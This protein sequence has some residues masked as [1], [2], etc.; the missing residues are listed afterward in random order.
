MLYIS[1]QVTRAKFAVVDTDDNVEQLAD[2]GELYD[3]VVNKGLDI[4][5]VDIHYNSGIGNNGMYACSITPYMAETNGK[6]AKLSML[7][8]VNMIVTNNCLTKFSLNA[9]VRNCTINLSD[10]CDS[11]ADYAT[12]YCNKPSGSNCDK[13][14]L[15]LDSSI[16]VSSK[17]FKNLSGSSIVHIDVSKCSDKVANYVYKCVFGTYPLYDYEPS[18]TGIIDTNLTRMYYHIAM[19]IVTYGFTYDMRNTKRIEDVIYYSDEL[20]NLVEKSLSKVFSQLNNARLLLRDHYF[21][22]DIDYIINSN[23]TFKDS[24]LLDKNIRHNILISIANNTTIN[25]VACC[26]LDRY[27]SYINRNKEF[28]KY[29]LNIARRYIEFLRIH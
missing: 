13:I 10:Y 3:C 4:K 6:Y 24:F 16:N 19:H 7:Y 14:I 5:G 25:S 21:I 9:N 18:K 12:D 15:V 26:Q 1:R 23:D 11:I 29:Y 17:A 22:Q 8:G 2:W 20:N 27:L 28:T